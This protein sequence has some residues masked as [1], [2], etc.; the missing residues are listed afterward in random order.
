[1]WAGSWAAYGKIGVIPKRRMLTALIQAGGTR[2]RDP[3][4]P[5]S[6]GAFAGEGS[7]VTPQGQESKELEY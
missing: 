4:V 7:G 5:Y 3:C 1:M 6:M 2:A